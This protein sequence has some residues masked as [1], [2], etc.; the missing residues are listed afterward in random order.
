MAA[1]AAAAAASLLGELPAPL[2]EAVF[3]KLP[4]DARARCA[5]VRRSWCST[6]SERRMWTALDL[7]PAGGVARERVTD[8]LLRGAAAKAGGCLEALDVSGCALLTRDAVCA[9]LAAHAG[10]MRQLRVTG[11][12]LLRP[13][14]SEADTS[15]EEEDEEEAAEKAAATSCLV[16]D[17][18]ERL[19]ASAPHLQTLVAD[20]CSTVREA[21]A[22]LRETPPL[23]VRH[24]L[25]VRQRQV[26]QVELIDAVRELLRAAQARRMAGLAPAPTILPVDARTAAL[27]AALHEHGALESLTMFALSRVFASATAP[28]YTALVA[29]PSLRVLRVVN[30]S[31][32][33][34]VTDE[35]EA[36]VVALAA[37]AGVC[38][39]DALCAMLSAS[40]SAL[41]ELHLV[42][43]SDTLDV[44][45]APVASALPAAQRLRVLTCR[46][47]AGLSDAF[48]RKTL[49]PALRANTSLRELAI[50]LR[51]GVLPAAALEAIALVQQ[52]A[53]SAPDD[54]KL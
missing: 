24:L 37:G 16:R 15:E 23:R 20:V 52:R 13:A 9:V 12:S 50:T 32:P 4:V 43:K 28:L 54:P 11:M 27:A 53:A 6:L 26:T 40:N 2:V 22:L 1:A 38:A 46:G 14:P 49:M 17:D 25:L 3:S 42:T 19:L 8:A 45:L 48:V 35:E 21:P 7:S 47:G 31:F 34:D 18:I 29:H 30:F 10:T 33:T 5:V 44:H 41:Q 51:D 36:A 39:G